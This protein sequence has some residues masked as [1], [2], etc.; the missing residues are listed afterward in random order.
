MGK[1][2]TQNSD[3]GNFEI[4]PRCHANREFKIEQIVAKAMVKS[5]F[6]HSLSSIDVFLIVS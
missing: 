6:V 4:S 3:F 5:M 1:K 2:S